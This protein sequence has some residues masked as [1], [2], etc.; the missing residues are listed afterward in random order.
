MY[1]VEMDVNRNVT[2][3]DDILLERKAKSIGAFL[4]Q[5]Y[6]LPDGTNIALF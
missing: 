5:Y 4:T 3:R 6:H 1:A 2:E